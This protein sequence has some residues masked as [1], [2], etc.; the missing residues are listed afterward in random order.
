MR[1]TR[2]TPTELV[3]EDSTVWISLVCSLAALPLIYVG[4]QA[5]R[6]KALLGAAL[7]ILFSVVWVR[8]KTFTFDA[9]QR[10]VR[11]TGRKLL[12]IE[13]GSIPFDNITDI[14]IEALSGGSSDATYRLTVL[15]PQGAV[16]MAYEYTGRTDAYAAMRLTILEFVHPGAHNTHASSA[17]S[18]DS[19]EDL[20]PAIRSLLQQ[21]RKIDAIA[22]LRAQQK[23]SLADAVARVDA[24]EKQRNPLN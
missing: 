22:L 14:G 15:T 17:L 2:Q 24:I 3:T 6:H 1:I 18:L 5:G 19:S 21:G 13:S 7:F 9:M 10:G 4:I 16:P 8:K 20:E 12:K 11:W 23:L